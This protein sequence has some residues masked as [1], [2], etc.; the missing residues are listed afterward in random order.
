MMVKIAVA[1]VVAAIAALSLKRVNEHISLLIVM[2]ASVMVAV[3]VIANAM[4]ALEDMSAIFNE[5]GL[6]SSYF[7]IIAK[8][9]GI[10]LVAQFASDICE[11][12]GYGS[13]SGQ[14]ILAA[15]IAVV[16]LSLP[17]FREVL[18]ISMR[19]IKG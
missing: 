18:N 12:A 8:C 1:C 17:L 6:N 9:L 15:K 2:A 5:S 14:I 19:L 16:V 10:C 13:L 11:D 3:F 7:K 4:N